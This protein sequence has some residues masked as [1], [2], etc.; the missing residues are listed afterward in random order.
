MPATHEIAE[1]QGSGAGTPVAGQS[2][3]V[4]GVVT[5]DFQGAAGLGGFF[6]QDATPDADPATSDGV[7]VASDTAV[8]AGDRV[9]V[10]GTAAEAFGHTRSRA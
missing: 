9:L 10:T 5:G 3:R 8:A 7:F 1:V 2:V 6:L 4:E